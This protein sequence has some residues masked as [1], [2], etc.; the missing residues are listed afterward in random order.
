MSFNIRLRCVALFSLALLASAQ[1]GRQQEETRSRGAA[2]DGGSRRAPER[3]TSVEGITEYRLAN[4]LRVLLFPD[5]EQA[6]HHGEHHLPGRL[7][8]RELRRDRHGAPA[9]THVVQGHGAPHGH[10]RRSWRRMARGPM[11]PPRGTAPTTTRPSTPARKTCAGRSI[12]K[13]TAW[14][15]PVVEKKDLDSEM[16]VVRNEFEMGENQPLGVL[17][18]RL[19]VG[20]LRLAQLRQPAHRRALG[21]RRRA[22]RSPAGL[23][24]DLLPAGQCAAAGGRQDRRG[25]DARAGAA[26]FRFDSETHAHPAGALHR[27][28]GAGRRTARDPAPHG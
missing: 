2:R 9:R 1:P 25:E 14:S 12:S 15:I 4:G 3:V 28:A 18:K 20:V 13:P 6:D 8:P 23:L 21:S 17:F 27:R 5:P 11:A 24:Q 22:D 16:T 19:H 26:V 7:A 10:S